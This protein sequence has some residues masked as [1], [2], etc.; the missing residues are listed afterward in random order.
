MFSKEIAAV[1]ASIE[2]EHCRPLH[3]PDFDTRLLI[4]ALVAAED[5]RFFAHHGV[6]CRGIVRAVF[7]YV[8]GKALQ[9]ASTITQQLVRVQLNDYR[10]NIRR[11]FKEICIAC[12]VDARVPKTTQA[13]AYLRVAYFG[14][15]MNGV[16]EAM[17]R[18]GLQ[19]PLSER[20]A[21]AV[22]ARLRFP[23]PKE[24][25][26]LLIAKIDR[27]AEYI[28]DLLERGVLRDSVNSPNAIHVLN[29]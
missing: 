28:S 24:S 11:K 20:Q 2:R 8:C 5:R 23:E 27:R 15:R 10:L 26:Q 4:R 9:G 21:A 6:D 13:T 3:I 1:V 12:A 25:S 19:S 16:V 14:W 22:V 29:D 17:W 7:V 18:M